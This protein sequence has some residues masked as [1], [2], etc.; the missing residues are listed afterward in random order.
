M[1]LDENMAFILEK[2]KSD[3]ERELNGFQG[4][5]RFFIY[6]EKIVCISYSSNGIHLTL[7]I[8]PNKDIVLNFKNTYSL[9][10]F[11]DYFNFLFQ[12]SHFIVNGCIVDTVFLQ[13]YSGELESTVKLIF[14]TIRSIEKD[15]NKCIRGIHETH[16][17]LLDEIAHGR[18]D[19]SVN[20]MINN[21]NHKQIGIL[22]TLEIIRDKELSISRFGDGE[23]RCMTTLN[24]CSFQSHDWELMAELRSISSKES[25]KLL[26]CYPDILIHNKFWRTFW[27]NYWFKTKGYLTLPLYGNSMISR[28]EAF[29]FFGKKAAQIWKQI[30][31]KKNVCFVTGS[32]SRLDIDHVLFQ[33]IA[34]HS[35]IRTKNN[36]AYQD[37]NLL[38]E[39]CI[40]RSDVEIFLIALGP[41]GSVL[42]ARL[43]ALGRRA[44]D[45]GHVN[46]S[47]DAVFNGMPQPEKIHYEKIKQC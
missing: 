9:E 47:Y 25:E 35:L 32:S 37:I 6:K 40:C 23:I 3:L 8:Y 33:N 29:N 28:P 38:V 27:K 30:F 24:G 20:D 18:E 39:E 41:T 17:L 10:L 14:N 42:A 15:T 19:L 34:S 26:V 31:Y 7:D 43:A 16:L 46:N 12:K 13:N 36:N 45:I 2:Y 4:V 1:A 44:L 21:F 11:S 5:N 22:E